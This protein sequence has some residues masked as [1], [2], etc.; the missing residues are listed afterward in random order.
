M[1]LLVNNPQFNKPKTPAFQLP[2]SK[3]QLGSLSTPSSGNLGATPQVSQPVKASGGYLTSDQQLQNDNAKKYPGVFQPYTK[4]NQL[5]G[6]PLLMNKIG[7]QTKSP[8]DN[9]PK[10]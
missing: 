6:S 7:V 5:G 1:P 3:P 8:T 10:Q 9:I 2:Q 4:P